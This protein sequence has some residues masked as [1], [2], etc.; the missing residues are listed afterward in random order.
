MEPSP[1]INHFLQPD[2]IIPNPANPQNW[3]RFSYAN[4][5][6]LRYTDPDGHF[7]I[8]PVLAIVAIA[9]V[10]WLA[11]APPAYAPSSTEDLANRSVAAENRTQTKV[12]RWIDDHP[13]EYVLLAA[14]V[15]YGGKKVLG[16][17]A[18]SLNEHRNERGEPY[19]DVI[20]PRT[21]EPIPYPEHPQWTLP[22]DS[23]R[24]I[25]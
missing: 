14:V 2:T 5:S 3:N 23:A 10:G 15:Y 1:Y 18:E 17:L 12:A 21:G 7:A 9:V 20:D 16:T 11:F 22:E 13:I 8:L 25:L 24:V 6:P 19:P 4:N